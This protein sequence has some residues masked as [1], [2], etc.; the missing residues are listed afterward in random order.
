MVGFFFLTISTCDKNIRTDSNYG[1]IL[2]QKKE[3]GALD[4]G[5]IAEI[6]GRNDLVEE[7]RKTDYGRWIGLDLVPLLLW[8]DL[9][10]SLREDL[11]GYRFTGSELAVPKNP[12]IIVEMLNKAGDSTRGRAYHNIQH[13]QKAYLE[14][15]GHYRDY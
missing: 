3:E 7:L 12:N 13:F 8:T 10:E 6:Y 2:F 11:K 9:P 14:E 15:Q 1:I 5:T 4:M